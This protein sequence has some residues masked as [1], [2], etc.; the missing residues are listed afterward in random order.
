MLVSAAF[1]NALSRPERHGGGGWPLVVRSFLAYRR[2]WVFFATGFLEPVLYLFSI[3]VGVGAMVDGFTF[4]GEAVSYAAF[5]APALLATSAMN[6]A[7]MDS[8][9]SVYFKL[10]FDKIYDAV[11]ATPM[12]PMDVARG[13]ITWAVLRG[14]IYS[15]GFLLIMLLMGYVESWWAVFVL[16]AAVLTGFAFASV[17]MALTTYMKSWQHFEYVTLATMPL[18]LFSGTFFPLE[19]YGQTAQWVVQATPLYHAVVLIRELTLGLVTTDSLVAVAYLMLMGGAGI[20]IASRRLGR[21][22]LT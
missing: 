13:E 19:T 10:K 6:G 12:T 17:G 9:F 1:T 4:H 11:L 22:L 8:T 7:V 3:G 2:A 16:P 15:A 20:W 5:V 14:A 21:L 18:F